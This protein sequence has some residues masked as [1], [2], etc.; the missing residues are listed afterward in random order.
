MLKNVPNLIP[1]NFLFLGFIYL[2]L[3]YPLTAELFRFSLSK[4]STQIRLLINKKGSEGQSTETDAVAIIDNVPTQNIFKL[5]QVSRKHFVI[6]FVTS[7]IKSIMFFVIW[8]FA[9]VYHVKLQRLSCDSPQRSNNI[10]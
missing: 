10:R 8:K 5:N 6:C 3:L 2:W 4:T 9:Q 1:P 7:E